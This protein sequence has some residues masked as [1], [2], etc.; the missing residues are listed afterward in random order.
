MKISQCTVP[1]GGLAAAAG[2]LLGA[3]CH[4]GAA[5]VSE[6][7][8]SSLNTNEWIA[9]RNYITD[10]G[11]AHVALNYILEEQFGPDKQR[12]LDATVER[13]REGRADLSM[14]L[15]AVQSGGRVEWV[16]L[17]GT[18]QLP[19]H[20]VQD[21]TFSPNGRQLGYIDFRS[22]GPHE[23]RV[24]I[25]RVVR[26][27]VY[28]SVRDEDLLREFQFTADSA[29]W[30]ATARI[31]SNQ[32]TVLLDGREIYALK[33]RPRV[34]V[35][36]AGSDFCFVDV[37]NRLQV[38]VHGTK[39]SG[40]YTRV[41]SPVFSADGL[42]FAF[43]AART[44]QW[45]FVYDDR[46]ELLEHEADELHLSE[47]GRQWA[48]LE[49]GQARRRGVVNGK[50]GPWY[51]NVSQL[52]PTA[53]FKHVAM[54]THAANNSC[55]IV[56]DGVPWRGYG[57]I[58]AHLKWSDNGEHLGVIADVRTKGK[59]R[60][61]RLVV[62][63]QPQATLRWIGDLIFSPDGRRVACW[64]R[65]DAGPVLVVDGT[66][67]AL[68]KPTDDCR[69][70]FSP[71]SRHVAVVVEKSHNNYVCAVDGVWHQPYTGIHDVTWTADSRHFA[72]AVDEGDDIQGLTPVAIV[73][74]GDVAQRYTE[75]VPHRFIRPERTVSLYHPALGRIG[76][77]QYTYIGRTDSG[78]L[79]WVGIRGT[80]VFSGRFP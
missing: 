23:T 13:W 65:G 48:W 10:A 73:I 25:D 15:R 18:N 22:G 71:D 50:A 31:P 78:G 54:V 70:Y 1:K 38:V 64:G 2:L 19:T 41:H 32:F 75:L 46:E 77:R 47:D 16:A 63:D 42:H 3:G 44:N 35:A 72:Y 30:L 40:P 11:R 62:D 74:D 59:V 49:R 56:V 34:N 7:T 53:D 43:L 28:A 80:K 57:R 45:V 37:T 66:E 69:I 12:R 5:A 51:Q 67:Q 4:I 52:V 76:E 39:T 24:V 68:P 26:S 9:W 29:H 8:L 36:P 58:D 60:S 55:R 21:L 61:N 20:T 27:K 6:Q 17:D 79:C 14:V 33:E